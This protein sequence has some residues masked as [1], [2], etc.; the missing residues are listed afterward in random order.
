VGGDK[1]QRIRRNLFGG[2]NYIPFVFPV[3]VVGNDNHPSAAD[4]IN[5][6]FDFHVNLLVSQLFSLIV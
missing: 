3:F 4:F 5:R 2:H 1:V 6:L